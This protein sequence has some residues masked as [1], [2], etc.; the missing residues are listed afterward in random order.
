[1]DEEEREDAN[2]TTVARSNN[3]NDDEDDV[4]THITHTYVRVH[5]LPLMFIAIGAMLVSGVA[6]W[7]SRESSAVAAASA[8]CIMTNNTQIKQLEL[9][10]A[11]IKAQTD[12]QHTIEALCVSHGYVPVILGGNIDCKYLPPAPSK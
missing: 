11:S 6:G 4:V 5:T 3:T 9:N 8:P 2:E 12:T 7:F 1:M 10:I